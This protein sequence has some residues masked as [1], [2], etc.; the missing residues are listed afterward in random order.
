MASVNWNR[1]SPVTDIDLAFPARGLELAPPDELIPDTL[2][3]KW[4]DFQQDWFMYGLP[5]DCEIDLQPGV[6]GN[7]AMRHLRVV[8]GCYGLKHQ[9][10]QRAVAYLAS[11]WFR[12]IRYTRPGLHRREGER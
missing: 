3:R 8:Q 10:K 11:L 12:D 4:L 6:D 9:H 5:E 7:E 1:P 2:D